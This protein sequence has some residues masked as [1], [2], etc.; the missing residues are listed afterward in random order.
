MNR[1]A[2]LLLHQFNDVAAQL[3]PHTPPELNGS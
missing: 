1:Y 2:H 3:R